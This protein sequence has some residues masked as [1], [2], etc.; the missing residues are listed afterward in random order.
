[1]NKFLVAAAALLL[2]TPS[3]A[4]AQPFDHERGGS[5]NAQN[6][7]H[8]HADGGHDR[9]DGRQNDDHQHSD[10]GRDYG[11][12]HHFHRGERVG[13]NDWSGAQRVDYRE[14]HLR[15]PPY[16]YEWRE[17]NGQYILAAI[18]TGV[19]VSAIFNSGR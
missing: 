3:L 11:G 4:A 7:E 10:W 14:H 19:I 18:A 6:S 2:A 8:Q 9:G 5:D 13:Y 1:M 16:G 17:S 12:G 15:R